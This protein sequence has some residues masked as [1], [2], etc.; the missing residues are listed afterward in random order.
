MRPIPFQPRFEVLENRCLLSTGANLNQVSGLGAGELSETMTKV[1]TSAHPSAPN[2]NV[3]IVAYVSAAAPAANIPA[4]TVTFYDNG[5]SFATLPLVNGSVSTTRVFAAAGTRILTAQYS[6]NDQFLPST[7]DPFNQVVR[8][9]TFFAASVSLGFID[10]RERMVHIFGIDGRPLYQIIMPNI[11][12][13][14][15][16]IAVGSLSSNQYDDLVISGGYLSS[17]SIYRGRGIADG[18]FNPDTDRLYSF[19]LFPGGFQPGHGA[20]VAIGDVNGDGYPDLIVAERT[21]LGHYAFD[22]ARVWVF[23]GRAFATGTFDPQNPQ[24]SLLTSFLAY[25]P[26]F[27]TGVNVAVGDVSG[28]GYADIITGAAWGNPHVKVFSGKAIADGT[29]DP[30]HPD[31]SLLA[32]YFAYGLQFN[33]GATVAVGDVNNAGYM[34][35]ITGASIGNPHVKVYNGRDFATGSFD[36]AHPEWSI[37]DEFFAFE[38][39]RNIGVAVGAAVFT[40]NGRADIITGNTGL[41]LE[42][43]VV[44][45]ITSYGVRPPALNGIEGRILDAVDGLTD[46]Y[47]MVA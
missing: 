34:D 20:T 28:D 6:G 36:P 17:I 4:G 30:N 45:G 35:V 47:L 8:S 15:P 13:E 11:Y 27:H 21:S 40:P 25:D 18:T 37:L 9:R 3:S 31:N 23:D 26:Q 39:N 22:G 44:D 42:Y 24:A 29:F 19:T 1:L 7:S 14:A 38:L 32:S 33:V 46:R 16:S 41:H 5:E 10:S 2:Q 12:G 43:R